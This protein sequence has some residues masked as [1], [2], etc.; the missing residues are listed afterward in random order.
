[1]FGPVTNLT[2]KQLAA[3]RWLG[4]RAQ[5]AAAR[6]LGRRLRG[7][8]VTHISATAYGGGVAELLK[9]LVP[10][11]QDVG[12]DAEWLV[13]EPDSRLFQATKEIHN[14]L[15]GKPAP[16]T[17]PDQDYYLDYGKRLAAELDLLETDLLVIHDPQPLSAL[18]WLA[19]KRPVIGRIHI[20]LSAP[21]ARTMAMVQPFLEACQAA[22][23]SLESFVPPNFHGDAARIIAPAI[24]PLTDKNRPLSKKAVRTILT[25]LGLDLNRPIITQISR[26][27]PWKD[28]VG[29]IQAF[30]QVRR[31]YPTAQLVLAG[32]RATDDPEAEVIWEEVVRAAGGNPDIFLFTNETDPPVHDREINALQAGSDVVVQKSLKEGFGLTVT[33]ALWKGQPFVGGNVGGIRLQVEHE[34]NGLL[35]DSVESCAEQIIRLLGDPKLAKQLGRAGQATVKNNYL[36]TRLLA[37]HLALYAELIK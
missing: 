33:E 23:F 26:F 1:M 8:K 10:L 28:P 30:E 5:Y 18:P 31:Q 9:S 19:G 37:D 32:S 21:E 7:R 2:P 17:Q 12:I 36:I 6:R 3:Y 25:D 35:C 24:D 14:A 15:Q 27:D 22:V 16:L 11:M 29:V 4:P 34:Q 13:L 20:D